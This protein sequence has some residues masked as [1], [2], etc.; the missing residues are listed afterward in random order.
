[1][2]V[3]TQAECSGMFHYADVIGAHQLSKYVTK[4][5]DKYVI[6][7]LFNDTQ[8]ARSH[9]TYNQVKDIDTRGMC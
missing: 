4:L 5:Y 1:M 7:V 2:N 9:T 3:M 6:D 8:M